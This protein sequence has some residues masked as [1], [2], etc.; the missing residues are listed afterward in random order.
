M[1][2][3]RVQ[4]ES[5]IANG[6]MDTVGEA[7][8]VSRQTVNRTARL[9]GRQGQLQVPVESRADVSAHGFWKWGTTSMFDIRIVNLNAC[10]YLRMTPGKSLAKAEKEKK[11]LNLQACLEHIHTFTPIV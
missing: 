9:E 3:A 11:Y 8:W 1:T 10:S 6:G 4:Q 2:G 5:G 7:Q